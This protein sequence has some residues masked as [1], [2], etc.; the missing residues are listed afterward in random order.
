MRMLAHA[1]PLR[2]SRRRRA[3]RGRTRE[4]YPPPGMVSS[5][6]TS[7][8]FTPAGKSFAADAGIVGIVSAIVPAWARAWSRALRGV[9]V[10]GMVRTPNASMER[11]KQTRRQRQSRLANT[12]HASQRIRQ[13]VQPRA[14][15]LDQQ[16]LKAV[17]R[18]Q[19]HV[20]RG[21]DFLE[22]L[23]LDA[24][25]LVAQRS[26]AIAVDERDRSGEDP[27]A[28]LRFALDKPVPDHLR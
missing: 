3:P 26:A 28:L 7:A 19:K 11:R 24:C 18:L 8:D 22:I 2:F 27:V 10:S 15:T 14:G 6:S 5:Q 17:I 23:R 21:D 1:S 9:D 16:H 20:L 25:E 13:P 4:Q 12:F